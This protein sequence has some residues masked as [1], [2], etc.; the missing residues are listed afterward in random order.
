MP[1]QLRVSERLHASGHTK[2]MNT[3]HPN[4][5]DKAQNIFNS[6]IRHVLKTPK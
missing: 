4:K 6:N 2:L 5:R 1:K 3:V